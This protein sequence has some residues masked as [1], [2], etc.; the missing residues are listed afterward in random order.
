GPMIGP[1]FPG[2]PRRG[3]QVA[4]PR[5]WYREAAARLLGQL[6]C[7]GEGITWSA[8]GP[9]LRSCPAGWGEIRG[10]EAHGASGER[11]KT[12]AVNERSSRWLRI[13]DPG[14]NIEEPAQAK[15]TT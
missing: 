6:P 13:A 10:N 9:D 8:P 3:R 14:Q 4:P 5:R 1:R 15:E 12:Q 11:T 2:R 7:L